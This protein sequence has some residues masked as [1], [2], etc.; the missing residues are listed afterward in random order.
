MLLTNW[1]LQ[2]DLIAAEDL[3]IKGLARTKLAKSIYDVAW[4][5][6]LTI[7][8]EAVALRGGVHFVKVSPHG[9]TIDCSVVQRFLKLSRSGF[10][11]VLNADY[12]LTEMKMQQL[13]SF[14]R[15]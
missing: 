9:T 8:E 6:F 12:K 5:K 7:L 14:I 15:D 1:F 4:G 10:M 3:N 11:N 13:I 2:Y